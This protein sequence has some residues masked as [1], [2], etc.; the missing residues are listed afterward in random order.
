MADID[1]TELDEILRLLRLH[2]APGPDGIP[3][4]L[5]KLMERQGRDLMIKL[6]NLMWNGQPIP[7]EYEQADVV[8]LYKGKGSTTKP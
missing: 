3:N 8:T 7:R 1:E 2:K 4:E 5:W 6:V